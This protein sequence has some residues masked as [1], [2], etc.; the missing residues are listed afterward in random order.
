[1][2][3]IKEQLNQIYGPV[4]LDIG[5]ETSEQIA[6]SIIAEILAVMGGK[7]GASLKNKQEKIHATIPLV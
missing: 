3:W 1:M 4:G 2:I 6:V 5:A 7:Q